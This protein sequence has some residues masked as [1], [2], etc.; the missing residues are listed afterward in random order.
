MKFKLIPVKKI[1]SLN[2]KNEVVYDLSVEV[3]HSYC[4][5]GIAVH[6]SGCTTKNATGIYHPM[7][8]LIQ[9][10]REYQ[11]KMSN[12]H[13]A[14]V[15]DGGINSPDRFCKSLAL[16]AHV[17]MMGSALAVAKESPAA[18]VSG[19]KYRYGDLDSFQKSAATSARIDSAIF[20][21]SA[22]FEVQ[23]EYREPRYIEGKEILLSYSSKSL[24]DIIQK[25]MN[26][27]RS[28]MSYFNARL[29]EEY[30]NNISWGVK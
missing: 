19:F 15:A 30:R 17:V 26:G 18:K 20:R 12:R 5:N 10:I 23:K 13:R 22:S 28:S 16:G 9:E 7:A 25:F 4:V 3:S 27:L 8:S 29:L 14:V 2:V 6:N 1:E 11:G 21:G 24:E